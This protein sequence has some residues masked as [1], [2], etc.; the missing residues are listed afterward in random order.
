MGIA[1]GGKSTAAAAL[2]HALGLPV[3]HLDAIHWRTGR[4]CDP[5]ELHAEVLRLIAQD[6]WVIDGNYLTSGL[7]DRLQRA[8]AVVVVEASRSKA[9]WRVT[10]RYL[11]QRLGRGGDHG[12]PPKLSPGFVRWIWNWPRNHPNLITTLKEQAPGTPVA[13][14]GSR[15]DLCRLIGELRAR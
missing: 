9:L 1:G 8:E 13:V 4:P 2:G 3:F 5:A 15:E 10:G 11:R 12:N 14:V 7:A 6:R